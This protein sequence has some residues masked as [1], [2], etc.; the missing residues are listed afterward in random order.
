M[1][2][3]SLGVR[4]EKVLRRVWKSGRDR[5]IMKK[6]GVNT[7]LNSWKWGSGNIKNG[8]VKGKRENGKSQKRGAEGLWIVGLWE[9][10]K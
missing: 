8:I 6:V 9:M 1:R 5:K 3:D 10:G 7:F 4:L 2:I